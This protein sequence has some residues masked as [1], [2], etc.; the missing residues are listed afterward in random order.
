MSGTTTTDDKA[1]AFL[2]SIGGPTGGRWLI[3][4]IRAGL[5]RNGNFYPETVLREAVRVFDGVRV[6]EKS[7][8]E[9][10]KREG[11]SV[12][13]LIGGLENPRF[14][15]GAT[16]ADSGAIVADLSLI[17]PQGGTATKLRNAHERGLSKLFG[18]SI[19]ADGLGESRRIQ[20]KPVRYVK[21]IGRVNSVDLIVEPGAGG[22]LV[23][24][25]E[26]AAIADPTLNTTEQDMALRERMVE[27]VKARRPDYTG[28]GI[29]DP[30]LEKD[31]QAALLES[32]REIEGEAARL[33]AA[34][35]QAEA[36]IRKAKL[37]DFAKTRL[38]ER[39]TEATALFAE[40]DV[41][42]AIKTERDYLA[43][44]SD[45][46]KVSLGDFGDIEVQDR[47][48]KVA[49][50]LDAFFDPSHKNHGAVRSFRECYI[51]VTGDRDITGNIRGCNLAR[52]REGTGLQL[53]EAV[54]STS[55]ANVLGD[56]ITRRM[57]KRFTQETD[58]QTWRKVAK[59]VPVSDFRTQERLRVGGY[60]NLPAVAEAASYD[61]LTSPGDA[62]AT[63]AVS[64]RGGTESVT[65][66]A[67]ANDDVQAI[68]DI[69]DELALAAANTLYEFVFD[70]FRSNPAIYDGTAFFHASRGN[71]FT[72]ALDATA[73]AAHRLAMVKQT[74]AG[75]NKRYGITP[76]ILVVP[77][78]LEEAAYNL[79]VRD[80]N[81]DPDFVQN[82][83][84]E[85]VTVAYWADANDWCTV[86]DPNKLPAVEIGFLNGKEE[87]ALFVQDM[88]N[89]GSLFSNDKITYKIRHIYG[90]AVP[91][92][93]AKAA[94]KAVVA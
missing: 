75:S 84:P 28:E 37:P 58:L 40:T 7:D 30:Q 18:F 91:V 21:G 53:R 49:D 85:V 78:D 41:E 17:E 1:G 33:K 57:L 38:V 25:L 3:R 88:P 22:E 29:A 12:R 69:P 44:A 34:K 43:Q 36:L 80:T 27:A 31:Y 86:A 60:G 79:F 89:A 35:D 32:A 51:E 6:F 77:F 82:V 46:G 56:A 64:K 9:H 67:I 83:K 92:D 39:F 20:G 55:W 70:F 5:S 23:T 8:A 59:V 63:Y 94:T 73:F 87:P 24:M 54:L 50:M 61:P 14:V 74:R 48:T 2:E 68:R 26:S 66:E 81:L 52:L 90:G 65:L 10:L 76:R 13:N 93:G 16:G 42:K 11:K 62:K 47:S 4:V 19:D 45:S 15:E 72:A 71:L